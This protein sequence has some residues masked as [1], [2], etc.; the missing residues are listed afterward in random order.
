MGFRSDIPLSHLV[1][2]RV[3]SIGSESSQSSES[4]INSDS[5]EVVKFIETTANG[6]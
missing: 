5:K 2:L 6:I 4:K 3:L 1:D